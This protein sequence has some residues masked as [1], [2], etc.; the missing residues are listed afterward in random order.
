MNKRAAVEVG[1]SAGGTALTVACGSDLVLALPE[2]PTTGFQWT[3]AQCGPQLNAGASSF[4][5]PVPGAA[6]AG[7]LRR[8]CFSAAL[9]GRTR[10][11]LLLKQP[12]LDDSSATT[13]FELDITVEP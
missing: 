2:N 1:P 12:W 9:P 11:R 10:L 5:A 13:S 4:N 6:G 3:V 8:I 7:G